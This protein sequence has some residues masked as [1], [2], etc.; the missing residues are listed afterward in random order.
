MRRWPR[1][2]GKFE[3][4]AQAA[5]DKNQEPNKAMTP[6]EVEDKI[7]A[8]EAAVLAARGEAQAAKKRANSALK[9]IRDLGI[10]LD[11][12]MMGTARDIANA[13]DLEFGKLD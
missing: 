5:T 1:Y 3:T 10:G 6:K 4:A 2:S 11:A 8:L 13:I 7:T 12:D 9:F